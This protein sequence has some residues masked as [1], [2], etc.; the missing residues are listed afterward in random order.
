[1]GTGPTSNI[2]SA[3]VT[4]V[5]VQGPRWTDTHRAWTFGVGAVSLQRTSGVLW[6]ADFLQSHKSEYSLCLLD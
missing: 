5:S 6:L 2:Q 3:H 4:W 1:M